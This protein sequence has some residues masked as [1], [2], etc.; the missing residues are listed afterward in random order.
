MKVGII[1][2][3]MDNSINQTVQVSAV[4]SLLNTLKPS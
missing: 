3:R 1:G 4:D 2:R